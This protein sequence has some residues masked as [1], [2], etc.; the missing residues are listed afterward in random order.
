MGRFTLIKSSAYDFDI[1]CPEC[2]ARFTVI[3]D[4]GYGPEQAVCPECNAQ[5]EIGIKRIVEHRYYVKE[6]K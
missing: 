6:K 3:D 5:F 4:F 2:N 1:R